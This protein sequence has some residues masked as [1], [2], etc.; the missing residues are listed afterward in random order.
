[1][2]DLQPIFA[3]IS[4]ERLGS[5]WGVLIPDALRTTHEQHFAAV[6]DEF[7]DTLDTGSTSPHVSADL[8]AKYTLLGH[9]ARIAGSA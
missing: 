7:L 3:G 2:V 8:M 4:C 1:M 6:L 9:A 5:A